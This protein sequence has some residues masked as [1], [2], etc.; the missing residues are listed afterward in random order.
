LREILSRASEQ[1][2]LVDPWNALGTSQVF[3]YAAEAAALLGTPRASGD[4][5]RI[6]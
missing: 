1:C 6:G 4:L 3:V 2:L 5:H